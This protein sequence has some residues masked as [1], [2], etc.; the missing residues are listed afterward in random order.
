MS[1]AAREGR[2]EGG[3]ERPGRQSALLAQYFRIK[4]QHQHAI[5]LFRLGDFYEAFFSSVTHWAGPLEQLVHDAHLEACRSGLAAID[6]LHVTAATLTG[7]DELV[8]SESPGKP[9]H[10]A[11]TVKVVSLRSL[12]PE[13]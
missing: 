1:D 4:A 12:I 6:A 13:G 7:A 3:G 9:I 2:A 5:L 11:T 10:R 8:T